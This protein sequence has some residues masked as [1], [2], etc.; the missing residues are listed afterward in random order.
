MTPLQLRRLKEMIEARLDEPITLAAMAT[1]AGISQFH[2][3]RQFRRAAGITPHQFVLRKRVEKA[4]HFLASDE[5]ASLADI[6]GQLG[7]ASQSHFTLVF[8]RLE[9][10][11]PGAYRLRYSLW[12]TQL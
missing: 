2:L 5:T 7:F 3:C 10:I 1:F 6:G 9:G 8:R 4:K 11:T 12:P